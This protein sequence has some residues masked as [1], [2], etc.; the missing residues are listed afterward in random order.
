MSRSNIE[1][2]YKGITTMVQEIKWMKSLLFKFGINIRFPL[3]FHYDN[4]GATYLTSNP[5]YHVKTKYIVID[6]HFV[7]ERMED[8]TS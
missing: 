5:I 3:Q 6:L 8:K 4:L 7:H 2:E 1:L